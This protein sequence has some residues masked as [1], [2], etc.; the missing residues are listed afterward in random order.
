LNRQDVLDVESPAHSGII[1]LPD[2]E[3]KLGALADYFLQFLNC[4]AR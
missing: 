3:Q 4:S 1:C 2:R